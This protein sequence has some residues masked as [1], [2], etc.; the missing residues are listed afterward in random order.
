MILKRLLSFMI[1]PMLLL[2]IGTVA[3]AQDRTVTG[4]VTDTSGNGLVGAT[5]SVKGTRVAVQ[6]TNDGLF[7]IKAPASASRLVIS[8]VGFASSEVAITGN[9]VEVI[10]TPGA[11]ANLNEVVV[12]GYGTARKRDLTGAVNTVSAK[13]FQKGNITTPEQ[14]IAGKVPGVA[15]TSNGGQPGSGSTIRIRGGSSLSASNDPLIVIDGVPLGQDVISGASNPLSFI[16]PNDIETFTVLKD[17]SAAA[18]YGSRAANGVIIIT[19]KKGKGGAFRVNFNSNQS[20]SNIY[21]KVD[22]LNGNEV[23]SVVNQYGNALQKSQI[24]TANT[25]WQN[26]I[27]Q[28]AV[29]TDNNIS[30]T[31][32]LKKLPYRLTLGYQYLNG[33]LKTDHLQK[34][35]AAF[36]LNPTFFDN[37]LRVDINLKGSIQQTR[38]ANQG[39][40][41][42]AVSFDPTQP[43]YSNDKRYGGYYEWRESN[44]SLVLNRANNPLG[45]LEQTFDKQKPM[46]SIGN[47]AFDYKFHFLPELRANLN[48]GYDVSKNDGSVFVPDSAASDYLNRGRSQQVKQTRK[49]SLLEFY[50]NYV[51]DIKSIDSRVDVTAGYSYNDFQAKNYSYRSLNAKGDT[52]AGS[53]RPA[54]PFDIPRYVIL[55]YFARLNYNLKSKYLLTAT[56]RRDGSS[57]FPKANRYGTFPSVALAWN[58]KSEPFLKNSKTFTDLKLRAGYGITGQQEGIGYYDYIARYGVSAL[59]SY[60]QLDSTFYRN[61]SPAGFNSALKWEQTATWNA[62]LDY[63][64]V[65]GRINGSIDFYLKKTKDLLNSVPQ[66]TGT[67]FALYVLSNVGS[68]ENRGVEFSINL[69]PIRNRDLTWDV[70][71]NA[72]YNKNK[73]TNLTIIPNDP[74][75][76]GLPTGTADGVNGFV[77]LN[78]VGSSKNTFYLYHQV[79]DKSGKPIEGLLEDVNRDGQINELDRYKG[80]RADPNFFLGFS[81]NVSYKK[82]TAGVVLRSNLNNYVYNNTFSNFGRRNVI[83]GNYTTGNASA[84]YLASG[85][86]GLINPERQLLSDYFLQNASF[87]RMDNLNIGYNFGKIAHDKATLRLNA[88][89]QNVFTIT[90]YQ[91]LDPE[92]S[93]GI[94]RNFYPRPR[95]YSLGIGLDF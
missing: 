74:K 65:N 37:H 86:T 90:K 88:V 13:D 41:G 75:Y 35:S 91:G 31:G 50:L 66:A 85:F 36:A 55:S 56:I 84:S 2:L 6:S 89:V 22:V 29:S 24:G 28:T 8:S 34:T 4:R 80:K 40:I 57:K 1:L 67:N 25:D 23:R 70:N 52:I 20:V 81:T 73:I 42:S 14:L 26:V 78:A 71:F 59:S 7:S 48:L 77:F 63:S 46:R 43:V 3:Q 93:N 11:V 83:I 27:Y 53:T 12:V 15:I 72:T 95:T 47:I 76:I 60:Y 38:F 64:F 49:N 79:Y 17:A 61:F 32:G 92:I 87:L 10:L 45:L 33:V 30:F 94:D 19:T 58:I 9:S 68:M 16:N 21:K 44:G 62:A 54:F 18:I 82:W 39:A 51:K 69:Q 5:I